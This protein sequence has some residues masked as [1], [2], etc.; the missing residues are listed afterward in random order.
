MIRGTVKY[1]LKQPT[2]LTQQRT[3]DLRNIS[4]TPTA[5]AAPPTAE[6]KAAMDLI[7]VDGAV[8]KCCLIDDSKNESTVA[9]IR[10][11]SLFGGFNS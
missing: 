6:P 5:A 10:H 7:S 3:R 1:S 2:A 11:P 8:T 4:E 9:E